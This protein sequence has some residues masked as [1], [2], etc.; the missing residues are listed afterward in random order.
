MPHLH[1]KAI[2]IISHTPGFLK[3]SV[4]IQISLKIPVLKAMQRYLI[5]SSLLHVHN[6]WDHWCAS[7]IRTSLVSLSREKPD[8]RRVEFAVSRHFITCSATRDLATLF[9]TLQVFQGVPGTFQFVQ[10]ATLKKKKKNK[11]GGY[12]TPYLFMS[13]SQWKVWVLIPILSENIYSNAVFCLFNGVYYY[14]TLITC[15]KMQY[16]K[17]FSALIYNRTV[18]N[19]MEKEI[20]DLNG[21]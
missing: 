1:F 18:T 4:G 6:S 12:F 7:T 13:N 2:Q 9:S 17:K 15:T 10:S 20:Q 3:I 19:R 16:K 14:N 21:G 11:R 8:C 5:I